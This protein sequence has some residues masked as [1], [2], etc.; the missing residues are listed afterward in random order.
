MPEGLKGEIHSSVWSTKTFLH[1]IREL[2]Y[3]QIKIGYQ[4]SKI[5]DIGQ[6]SVL[7]SD[8]I[9]V[10]ILMI[11]I[12]SYFGSLMPDRNEFELEA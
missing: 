8:D 12:Y 2:R 1:D 10:F 6:S 4:I 3:K 5:L 11:L 9:D 7:K